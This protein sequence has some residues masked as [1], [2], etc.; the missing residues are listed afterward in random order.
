MS[1]YQKKYAYHCLGAATLLLFLSTP[2]FALDIIPGLKGFGT[3]TRAAYGAANTPE[4][5]IVDNLTDNTGNPSWNSSTYS[6]GVFKGSLCQCLEG[7]DTLN[8]ETI[9]GHVVSPNSGKI[10]LFE[11]SGT[12]KEVAPADDGD[13]FGYRMG[14]YTIIAGQTSPNPGILLRNICIY[15]GS[16]HDILIQHLRGRMDGPPSI[17]HNNHKSFQFPSGSGDTYN[18]VVDHI[19]AAWGADGNIG[20]YKSTGKL[21]DITMSNCILAEARENMGLT[22]EETYNGKNCLIGGPSGNSIN[23]NNILVYGNLFSN[24]R[25]RNPRIHQSGVVVVNNY[26]YNNKD[27][28]IMLV[29]E[30][31]PLIVS[32]VGNVM[33]GGPMSGTYAS[34]RMPNFLFSNWAEPLTQH[35]IY[36]YDNETDLGTQSESTDWLSPGFQID[37]RTGPRGV[38]DPINIYTDIMVAQTQT[39]YIKTTGKTPSTDAP[40]WPAGLTLMAS[41]AVKDYII[42]NAGAYPA[43]RDSLDTRFINEMTNGTGPSNTVKGTPAAGDWPTLTANTTTL[44]IPANPHSDDDSDGYTNLEEWLHSMAAM[45]EGKSPLSLLPPEKLTITQ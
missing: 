8:G 12:I 13:S 41:S 38:G 4:I 11:T 37:L 26:I 22:D 30:T 32:I 44:V 23:S 15:G 3:D 40:L 31:A 20:F 39:N 35:H 5:C 33:E 36:L 28:G 21:H 17:N 34:D 18:I 42:A 16:V 43:F 27:F 9:D 1:S 10:I 24:A 45:V 14:S 2:A 19:S 6:V 7:L 29:A 25:K